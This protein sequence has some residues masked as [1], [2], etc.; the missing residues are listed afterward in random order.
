M[1]NVLLL[2]ISCYINIV[3]RCRGLS[4]VLVELKELLLIY[5]CIF[6][7]LVNYSSCITLVVV[8]GTLE[9]DAIENVFS[10]I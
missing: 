5:Q 6:C 1:N 10:C 3:L 4:I 2:T 9:L 8:L 7:V